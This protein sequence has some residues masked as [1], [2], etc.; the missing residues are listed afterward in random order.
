MMTPHNKVA[1]EMIHHP[2]LMICIFIVTLLASTNLSI[3]APFIAGL[4]LIDVGDGGAGGAIAPPGRISPG[5]NSTE[6]GMFRLKIIQK[7]NKVE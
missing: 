4:S 5:Q 2:L 1:A 3:T 7:V 6:Q